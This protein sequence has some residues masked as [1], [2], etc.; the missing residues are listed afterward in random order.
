MKTTAAGAYLTELKAADGR[1]IIFPLTE[2][3][4]KR[5]GGSHICLPYFGPDLD[6]E[7]AQHGYGRE[8][9]WCEVELSS[10]RAVYRHRQ[11]EGRFVGLEAEL[12]YSLG[13]NFLQT[14]LKVFN[15]AAEAMHISP[16]FH[17]YFAVNPE[18]IALDGQA[19]SLDDYEP[20]QERP[21][22]SRLELKGAN[23][24]VE[25]SSDDLTHAVVWSDSRGD[26]LCVEPTLAGNVFYSQ[27]QTGDF[28]LLPGEQK[29]FSYKITWR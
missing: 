26:Y 22:S 20:F 7:L 12:S 8:V 24:Q 15:G 4:G 5:R 21:G 25:I 29:S 27:H 16:G 6:G 1:D 13:D 18:D 11:T 2:L 17:P 28:E 14:E 23:Y 19:I 9:E 3:Q 10:E